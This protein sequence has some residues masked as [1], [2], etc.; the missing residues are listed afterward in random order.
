[1]STLIENMKLLSMNLRDMEGREVDCEDV[2]LQ[3]KFVMEEVMHGQNAVLQS[4]LGEYT[5][6]EYAK[7][8][9]QKIVSGFKAIIKAAHEAS[10]SSA[11]TIEDDLNGMADKLEKL[12][13]VMAKAE[14]SDDEA[15]GYLIHDIEA[16]YRRRMNESMF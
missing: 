12:V 14:V 5:T 2:R 1:M 11:A 3:A 15:E 9:L 8:T 7:P 16:C 10:L 6:W 13:A 4:M